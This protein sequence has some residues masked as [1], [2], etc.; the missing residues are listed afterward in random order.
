MNFIQF[1]NTITINTDHHQPSILTK[2]MLDQNMALGMLWRGK[3]R[4]YNCLHLL[5]NLIFS[6]KFTIM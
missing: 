1:Q 4:K 2:V 5:T 3:I 6:D